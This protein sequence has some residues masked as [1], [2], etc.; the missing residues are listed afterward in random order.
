MRKDT[1][2]Q[3]Q[4]LGPEIQE[5]QACEHHWVID[6]PNG[7]S[8]RGLCRNCG[9][10]REFLNYS[11]G[12]SWGSDVSLDQLAGG[13]RVPIRIDVGAGGDLPQTDE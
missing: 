5:V 13:S 3:K 7:P 4:V 8:S 9:E 11:E 2:E 6:R 1:I 12:S 10:A